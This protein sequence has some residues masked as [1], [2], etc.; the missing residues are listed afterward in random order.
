M[1]YKVTSALKG[2]G[3]DELGGTWIADV[4]GPSLRQAEKA[5]AKPLHRLHL[6]AKSLM[7]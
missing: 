1:L 7:G 6:F 4:N 5:G 3:Y 2:A